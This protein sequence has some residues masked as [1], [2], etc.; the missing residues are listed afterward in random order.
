MDVL[1]SK[2]YSSKRIRE[3]NADYNILIGER[4]NGKSY[5]T[6]YNA[7]KEAYAKK[8]VSFALI[9][10]LA[11]DL[12]KGFIEDYFAD[13]P[14]EKITK[15]EYNYI[16][17]WSDNIYFANIDDN[18]KVVRGI[19]IGKAISLS[20]DERYKSRAYPD[21]DT[22]IFEEFVTSNL[23]L[24]DEVR[25][26]MSLV[27]T[28]FRRRKGCKV[29]MIANTVSRVCPYFQEWSLVNIPKMAQ[30]QID[31]YTYH[32]TLRDGSTTDTKIAVEYCENSDVS[33]SGMFFGKFAKHID[34]GQWETDEYPHLPWE[35]S[36][37]ETIYT[38]SI[39]SG[40]FAFM[41][42]LII[43]N[44]SPEQ[45]VYI[46]PCRQRQDKSYRLA[47]RVIQDD[48]STDMNITNGIKNI[49]PEQR[50]KELY[51][52]GKVVFS[53]N[54]CGADFNTTIKNMKKHP[55]A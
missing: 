46:Y 4:A 53:T 10:R 39:A 7:L 35:S 13:M 29:W 41:V 48:F 28:I 50:I 24:R 6:K 37:Y 55:F 43:K 25:R 34:G 27:S 12:K 49:Y 19:Q 15:N 17:G 21:M 22:I 31:E 44:D 52:L 23:Y 54:L 33:A 40:L 14:V 36:E 30:G 38:L 51:K 3:R 16:T 18:G 2:Y 5:D 20:N 42:N 8:K 32:E 26:L 9:K 11:E 45:L 47:K 1:M